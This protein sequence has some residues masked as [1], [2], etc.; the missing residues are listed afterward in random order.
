MPRVRSRLNHSA[1]QIY[2]IT[3]ET[4]CRIFTLTFS[5]PSNSRAGSTRDCR[6][7]GGRMDM[8]GPCKWPEGLTA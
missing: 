5:P 2:H 6:L 8:L 1:H 7:I 3:K 4:Q